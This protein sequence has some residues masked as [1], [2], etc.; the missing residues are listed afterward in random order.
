[1]V[2]QASG[3]MGLLFL[4]SLVSPCWSQTDYPQRPAT[5]ET[6]RMVYPQYNIFGMP[7]RRAVRLAAARALGPVRPARPLGRLPR[8]APP[9][10]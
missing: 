5:S 4:L 6:D 10:G 8:R 9:R 2:K 1:M 7:R 3:I